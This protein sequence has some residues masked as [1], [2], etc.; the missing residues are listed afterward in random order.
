MDSTSMVNEVTNQYM[1]VQVAEIH[2][3]EQGAGLEWFCVSDLYAEGKSEAAL[4]LTKKLPCDELGKAD[5]YLFNLAF[6]LCPV[7]L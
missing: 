5:S 3:I 1:A 4:A 2:R 6:S 7:P